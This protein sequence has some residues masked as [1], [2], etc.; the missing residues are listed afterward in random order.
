VT[1]KSLE[2][3]YPHP[4]STSVPADG[5]AQLLAGQVAMVKLK[6][7]VSECCVTCWHEASAGKI[8]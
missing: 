2:S 7:K 5:L 1:K 3:F 8:I 4:T 6:E